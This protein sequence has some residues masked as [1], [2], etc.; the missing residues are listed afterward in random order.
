MTLSIFRKRPKRL[1][2]HLSLSQSDADQPKSIQKSN[3]SLLNR[4]TPTN[5]EPQQPEDFESDAFA[6]RHLAVSVS[7]LALTA[8][9]A[10]VAPPLALL[11]IP[12]QLYNIYPLAKQG[13]HELVEQKKI[14]VAGID[15]ILLPGVLFAGYFGASALALFL[16][17]LGMVVINKTEER[18]QN[19]LSN[20]FS[21]QPQTVWIELDGNEIEIPFAEVAQGDI[22]IVSAGQTIPV[23]GTLVSG[24]GSVDQRMLTGESQPTEVEVNSQVFAA[25]MLLAGTIRVHVDKAGEETAAARIGHILNNT[26]DFKHTLQSRGT[27]LADTY[28]PYTAAFSAAAFLSGGITGALAVLYAGLGY[29]MRIISPISMLSYLHTTA[30]KGILIKDARSFDLLRDIDTIVF[31]KTGTLTLEQPHV[32]HIQTYNGLAESELLQ[33]AAAAE[34]KQPH[35]IA[36]AI[37]QAAEEQNLILPDISEAAYEVGYGIKVTVGT[38]ARQVWVGSDRF[39]RMEG[40][41]LSA[42]VLSYQAECQSLGHSLVMVAVDGVLAGT[43]ELEPTIRPEAPALIEELRARDFDMY[44]ISGDQEQPTR[45]LAGKLGIDNY[46]ADTLPENKALLIEQLQEEGKR[47]CFIGDGINDTIALKKANLSIS[48]QGASLAATDTAQIVLLDTSLNRIIDLLDISQSF[49]SNM[50]VNLMTTMVPGLICI[51]GV[52]FLH[53]GILPAIMLYNAGLVAGI[54]NAVRPSLQLP[55]GNAAT[56]P[57][58]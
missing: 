50:N 17:D 35:P 2:D 22:V 26:V 38:P 51:G 28:A 52:F 9:G 49:E 47:V 15:L 45:N 43:L 39:M 55:A 31:D 4:L 33:L 12:G 23:D 25:T 42:A 24:V 34:H 21:Q 18:S 10:F 13:Y 44:I 1:I 8:A 32:V 56:A 16:I 14:T 57:K 19:K 11:S 40:I 37:L 53:F 3:G 20:L 7:S 5:Q 36:R 30:Q 41:E 54:G 6:H 46:F 27:A 48:M 58:I 29:N